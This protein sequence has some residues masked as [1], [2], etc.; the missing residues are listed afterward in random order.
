MLKQALKL[1]YRFHLLLQKYNE[2][3]IEDAIC[4][5]LRARLEQRAMYHRRQASFIEVKI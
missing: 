3:L 4:K 5:E 2:A 1:K